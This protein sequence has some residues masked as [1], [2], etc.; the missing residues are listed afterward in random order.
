MLGL[1]DTGSVTEANELMSPAGSFPGFSN[2]QP[3]LHQQQYR[4]LSGQIVVF[5]FQF[6]LGAIHLSL[7]HKEGSQSLSLYQQSSAAIP[8]TALAIELRGFAWDRDYS[9]QAERAR[10][11]KVH[12]IDMDYA[13]TLVHMAREHAL[14]SLIY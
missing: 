13:M 11:K 14:S 2:M 3:P 9:Q 7:K 12:H 5:A 1:K 4:P 8:H 6:Y 10:Q